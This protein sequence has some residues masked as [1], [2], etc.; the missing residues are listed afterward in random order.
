VAE[1]GFSSALLCVL[2][3]SGFGFPSGFWLLAPGFLLLLSIFAALYA[4][5]LSFL[6]AVTIKANKEI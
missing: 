4:C 2:C 3:G 5:M 1:K 6:E